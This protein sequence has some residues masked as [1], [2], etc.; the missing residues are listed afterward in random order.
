MELPLSEGADA[1]RCE[2]NGHLPS[3]NSSNNCVKENRRGKAPSGTA[4]GSDRAPQSLCRPYHKN[5]STPIIPNPFISS[6]NDRS[7]RTGPR[8]PSPSSE[9]PVSRVGA[10]PEPFWMNRQV[11]SPSGPSREI[12]TWV[13]RG[14][15][16]VGG[17]RW[18]GRR[19]MPRGSRCPAEG[20]R[21]P[22]V[23]GLEA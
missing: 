11:S 6:L 3:V 9:P 14:P 4:S 15:S 7:H 12:R 5:S 16:R 17:P 18:T 13:P 10:W 19:K 8:R 2:S 20:E 22:G 1:E 23:N 21:G